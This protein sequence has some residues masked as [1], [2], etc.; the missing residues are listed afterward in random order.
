MGKI[1]LTIKGS[2]KL[3]AELHELKSVRRPQIIAAIAEARAH[4]DL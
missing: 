4:G 3:R 2:E 1:P